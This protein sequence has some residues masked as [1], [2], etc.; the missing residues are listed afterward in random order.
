MKYKVEALERFK[1]TTIN[2]YRKATEVFEV[3]EERK[4]VLLGKNEYNRAFVK[5]LE[6]VE[7]AAKEQVNVEKAV[8]GRKKAVK[9]NKTEE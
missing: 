1:D 5:V 2:D 8:K 4:E 3:T 6:E 9:T 7:Q